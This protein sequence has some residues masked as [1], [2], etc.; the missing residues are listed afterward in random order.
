MGF[1][2]G[3]Y[4]VEFH[5]ISVVF[6]LLY[7]S[8]LLITGLPLVRIIQRA[9]YSGWWVLVSVVP[10]LNILALWYFAFGPWPA[11]DSK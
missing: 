7:L 10:G 9:G 1:Q 11:F 2:F 6:V 4:F 5:L 3:D 8:V